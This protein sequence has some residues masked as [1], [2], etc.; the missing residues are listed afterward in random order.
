[1]MPELFC[2]GQRIA[3]R[4]VI[5]HDEVADPKAF[6]SMNASSCK[7]LVQMSRL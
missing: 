2:L 4:L 7:R 3:E 5:S 1:M 6:G